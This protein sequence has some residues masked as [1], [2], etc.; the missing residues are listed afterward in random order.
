M[1]L[2]SNHI[3]F[4]QNRDETNF[5]AQYENHILLYIKFKSRPP[6]QHSPWKQFMKLNLNF[7]F[8]HTSG[9]ISA[10]QPVSASLVLVC[11]IIPTLHTQKIT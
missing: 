10:S 3:R 4:H 6:V 9:Q 11:L 2:A 7:N 1:I 5:N 8:L